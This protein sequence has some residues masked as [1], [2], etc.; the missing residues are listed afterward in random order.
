M[1]DASTSM[2]FKEAVAIAVYREAHAK[3]LAADAKLQAATAA[4]ETAQNEA[5]S[6]RSEWR[7][8]R[9]A[10]LAVAGSNGAQP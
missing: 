1:S 5:E 10:L 3:L 7:N 6:A 2:S 9:E 8:A 4:L